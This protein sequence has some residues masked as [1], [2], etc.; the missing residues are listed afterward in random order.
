[1]WRRGLRGGP[2][3]RP[4]DTVENLERPSIICRR[5]SGAAYRALFHLAQ[6]HEVLSMTVEGRS[7]DSEC[8]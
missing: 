3:K 4:P 7:G 5:F 2:R 8:L 1:M 6:A